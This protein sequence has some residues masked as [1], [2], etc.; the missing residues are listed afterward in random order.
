MPAI[1]FLCWAITNPLQA[2]D[3]DRRLDQLYHTAWTTRDGTPTLV[4]SWAQTPD[5]FLWFGGPNGLYRFDGIKF[6]RFE[7]LYG[8]PLP[9]PNAY[10]MVSLSDGSLLIGWG[11][12]GMSVLKN[13]QFKDLAG[14]TSSLFGGQVVQNLARGGD[15]T[16]WAD[17]RGVGIFRM[18]DDGQWIRFGAYL[19]P[20]SL[21]SLF[22][23]DRQGT[24]WFGSE[25]EIYYLPRGTEKFQR[26]PVGGDEIA[27]S[28]NGTL[29][30]KS[31]RSIR[32]ITP[33]GVGPELVTAPPGQDIGTC[34][35][36]DSG[37]SIWSGCNGKGI[38]RIQHPEN[39]HPEKHL[40]VETFATKDGLT[41]DIITKIF[42]DREGDV[43]IVTFTGIDCFRQSNIV[44][45]KLPLS[46]GFAFLDSSR[47]NVRVAD[48]YPS[49]VMT[50]T[51]GSVTNI[52]RLPFQTIYSC[53]GR[54]GVH[55]VGTE[56]HSLVK[57][58]G[59]HY[60]YLDTPTKEV[61]M[62][63]EDDKGRPWVLDPK[64]GFIRFEAGKWTK[65][66][67]LGGPLQKPL[68]SF[69]DSAARV[70]FG[71]A[72]NRVAML[73][74]DKVA[75]YSPAEGV[76][77]GE[78][79]D[80]R[81]AVGTIVIGGMHGLEMFDGNHFFPVK[82]N[83]GTS[84][85]RVWAL[86]S[87]SQ[88]GLWFAENRGLI[89]IPLRELLLAKADP[90]RRVSFEILDYY[91]GLSSNL[92]RTFYRPASLEG[93]DGR[94]W[95]A[96]E[97]GIVWIDP[98][99]VIRNPVAPGISVDSI[100]ANGK[101]YHF[102]SAL[103]L[104]PLT[105]SIRIAFAA[106]SASI[107]QRVRFRYKLEGVD[108]DW[109]DSG[110][111]RE[112]AYTN[113]S[114]QSYRFRVTASNGDGVWNESGVAAS[115]AIAPTWYQ[116]SWFEG[117]CALM[118]GLL[119]AGAY[120]LRVRRISAAMDARFDERLRERSR[121]ARELH[122]TLL[123]SF[124]GSLFEFQ[125]ARKLLFSRPEEAR[126]AL[127]QAIDSAKAAIAEGRD[128]IQGLRHESR[129]TEGLADLIRAVG[130]Q[131]LQSQLSGDEDIAFDVT[132]EG[133]SEPLAPLLQD[134]LFRIC[135]EILRNA[136][137]HARAKRIEV[138]I[139]YS[140]RELRLRIRDDGTGIDPK[141][142]D[143][144]ARPGHWGLPG[145]R[146]RA[147]LIGARFDLWSEVAAGTEIQITVPASRAY[148]MAQGPGW[149]QRFTRFYANR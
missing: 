118:A 133:T 148:L 139:R 102:L 43:W 83:D 138:E 132:V 100:F 131:G 103:T 124:Q 92:Q 44:S 147:K 71:H 66:R 58:I 113:L 116:T 67:D 48:T 23:V 2:M 87:S 123:Q 3:R 76:N 79:S 136:F 107:P 38:T 14:S 24:V 6:E 69:T 53:Q 134:E 59:N 55:W 89:H 5:G 97:S 61:T 105:T 45:V 145:A 63:T 84:F 82:P 125:A 106:S 101:T 141:V 74:E 68:S 90:K 135:Q 128:A 86:L 32:T 111:R 64:L 22:H 88:S 36:V 19:P 96:T 95:Y 120:R 65:L 60:E 110:A 10:A 51:D 49:T 146:E 119:V 62:V 52:D 115:F 56:A 8:A 98:K 30:L 140:P 121:I 126:P 11:G 18:G 104:P 34:I 15:D 7:T 16:I 41:N 77:V 50:I 112:A 142:L 108:K 4:T 78:V 130:N 75:V 37:G 93:P 21:Q 28:P 129:N 42:E 70:W 149:F 143:T 1:V 9:K 114:P 33:G 85:E 40:S 39:M 117:L 35:F 26:I 81:E 46:A 94:V 13:G 20:P 57:V 29:W 17:V 99:G 73:T 144:G 91:D 137:R 27:E 127:D 12:G 25:K 109:Q 54:N 31:H 80:I 72:D 47:D 122:D